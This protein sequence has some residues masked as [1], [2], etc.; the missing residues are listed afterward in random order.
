MQMFLYVYVSVFV[1]VC[2]FVFYHEFNNWNFFDYAM[3]FFKFFFSCSASF[4]ISFSKKG[5][6][7]QYK[8]RKNFG[9]SDKKNY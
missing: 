4:F 7:R 9:N 5:V 8:N 1:F 3:L 2:I 6:E